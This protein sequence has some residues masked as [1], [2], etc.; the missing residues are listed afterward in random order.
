MNRETVC[1]EIGEAILTGDYLKCIQWLGGE[2]VSR[3]DGVDEEAEEVAEDIEPE[4]VDV[5]VLAKLKGKLVE[6]QT[7]IWKDLASMAEVKRTEIQTLLKDAPCN[8]IYADGHHIVRFDADKL[9]A[10]LG[11]NG[12]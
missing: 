10:Y 4:N 6:G 5:E 1:Q 7:Y 11:D 12:V 2:L 8:K 9:L 3:L